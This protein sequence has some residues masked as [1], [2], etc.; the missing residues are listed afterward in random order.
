MQYF[1]RL[2][3]DEI[4]AEARRLLKD[5]DQHTARSSGLVSSLPSA[6]RTSGSAGARPDAFEKPAYGAPAYGIARQVGW[7]TDDK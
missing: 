7:I 1:H 2:S 6:L 5:R 4:M 3:E